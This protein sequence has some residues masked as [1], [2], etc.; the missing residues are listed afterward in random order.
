MMG[1]LVSEI[2]MISQRNDGKNTNYKIINSSLLVMC[3][4]SKINRKLLI[5]YECRRWFVFFE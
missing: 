4:V 1:I 2:D 3:L 5:N